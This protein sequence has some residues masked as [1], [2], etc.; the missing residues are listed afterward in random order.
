MNA[1][2]SRNARR[3][4]VLTLDQQG[5][6]PARAGVQGDPR[7]DRPAA[8]DYYVQWLRATLNP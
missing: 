1:Q 4:G 8:D 5:L 7:A 3:I 6:E 2:I